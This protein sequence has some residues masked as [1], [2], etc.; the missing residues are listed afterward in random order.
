MS[1]IPGFD[2]ESLNVLGKLIGK[3]ERFHLEG[4][5]P[6]DFDPQELLE[7]SEQSFFCIQGLSNF[8]NPET[9]NRSGS[10]ANFGQYMADLV[11]A[12]HNQHNAD[13]TLIIL[14]AP[15]RNSIYMS[16]GGEKM[17]RSILE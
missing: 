6:Q 17:T 12:S 11:I 9:A 14:S 16:L 10:P 4:A 13:L 7:G 8:W 15:R 3:L 1:V 5:I 2:I